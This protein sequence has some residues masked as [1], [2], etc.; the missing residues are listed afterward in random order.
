MSQHVK[1]KWKILEYELQ[2]KIAVHIFN[3][4]DQIILFQYL[5]IENPLLSKG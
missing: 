2:L 3:G 4:F 5:P 1:N